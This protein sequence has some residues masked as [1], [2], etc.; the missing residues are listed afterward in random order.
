MF[1]TQHPWLPNHSQFGI[2]HNLMAYRL[3]I[4]FL[5]TQLLPIIHFRDVTFLFV[6]GGNMDIPPTYSS[7][8]NMISLVNLSKQGC[9]QQ[10]FC[11][12]VEL[13]LYLQRPY[14][15]HKEIHTKILQNCAYVLF[16]YHF[17]PYKIFFLQNCHLKT[18]VF[19]PP[20]LTLLN[21]HE[22]DNSQKTAVYE[23][24]LGQP[25]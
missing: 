23:G 13:A 8:V 24:E 19:Q 9:S 12:L 1:S 25:F 17:Q 4:I 18:S 11:S 14:V 5:P 3:L 21:V 15:Q 22:G 20:T 7:I 10:E 6:L 16:M 2:L